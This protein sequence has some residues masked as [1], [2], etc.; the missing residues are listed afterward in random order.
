[1]DTKRSQ[2]N[3]NALVH[4]TMLESEIQEQGKTRKDQRRR[5]EEKEHDRA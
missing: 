1:M 4:A 2:C 5:C 3:R